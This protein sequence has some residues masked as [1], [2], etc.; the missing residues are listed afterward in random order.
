MNTNNEDSLVRSALITGFCLLLAGRLAAQVPTEIYNFLK[1]DA[2]NAPNSEG[3]WPTAGV[4][5]VSNMFYG[6]TAAGGASGGGTVFGVTTNGTGFVDLYDFPNDLS[7]STGIYPKYGLVASGGVLYGTTQFGGVGDGGMV[8]SINIDGTSP[9]L[10]HAFA[11]AD[12]TQPTGALLLFGKTLYGTTSS[13][14]KGYGTVF[15]I[16]TDGTGFTDLHTFQANSTVDIHNDFYFDPTDGA[17]PMDGVILSADGRTLYGTTESGGEGTN[18]AVYAM[19]IDGT[20]FRLLYS[21]PPAS[22]PSDV[23]AEGC[24]PIGGLLLSA[25]GATLYG[26]TSGGGPNNLG[27]AYSVST[28]GSSFT[29]LHGFDALPASRGGINNA[30]VIAPMVLSGDGKVLYGTSVSDTFPYIGPGYT[31]GGSVFALTTDGNNFAVLH[32]FG[33]VWGPN[34][35][36]N[37]DGAI[38]NQLIRVG[39]TLYSATAN[40]GKRGDGQGGGGTIFSIAL[41]LVPTITPS[42]LIVQRGDTI[43]VVVGVTNSDWETIGGVQLSAPIIVNSINGVVTPAGFSGPTMVPSLASMA[44]ASFTYLFTATNYGTA[45]FTAAVAGTSAEGSVTSTPVT[46]ASITVAPKA[47]LMVRGAT[48]TRFRGTGEFMP[49]PSGDQAVF[50]SVS[51]SG[52]AAYV[53]RIQNDEASASSFLLQGVTNSPAGWTVSVLSGGANIIGALTGGGWTT[54]TL[55]PGGYLDLQVTMSPTSAAGMSDNKSILISALAA[56]ATPGVLDSL[57]LNATLVAIPVTVTVNAVGPLPTLPGSSSQPSYTPGSLVASDINAPLVPITDP[58]TLDA[59]LVEVGGL[60]ADGVTPLVI[61]LSADADSLSSLPKGMDFTLAPSIVLGGSLGNAPIEQRIQV[62]KDGDWQPASDVVLTADAPVAYVQVAPIDSDD[63]QFSGMPPELYVDFVVQDNSGVYAGDATFK[64]RKP[65]IALV[66]GY[67]SPGNWGEDFK[68]ILGA[69]RPYWGEGNPDNFVITVK[70]GQDEDSGLVNYIDKLTPLGPVYMN[71]VMTLRQCAAEL[72]WRLRDAVQPLHANWAFTRFDM[73]CH[74]QGGLLARMLCNAAPNSTFLNAFRNDA[75]C[76]R[77]RFHRVVTIGSPHN[78]S[79]LLRYLL[80]LLSAQTT[81]HL[82][83]IQNIPGIQ[84]L[85]ADAAIMSKLAQAKFDPFGDQIQ[86]LNGTSGAWWTDPNAQFHLVRTLIDNGF[87][88]TFPDA[89]PGYVLLGLATPAGGAA[90]L[91]RGSDGIVDLDSMGANVPPAAVADNVFTVQAANDISH[92][93]PMALFGAQ[94][95]DVISTVV[96]QHVVGALDQSPSMN[97]DDIIFDRFPNPPLLPDSQRALIDG[98]AASS[99]IWQSL[100]ASIAPAPHA[101]DGS[102][103]YQFQVLFPTNLPPLSDVSWMV[104]VYDAAGIT[105]DGVELTSGGPSNSLVTVTVDGS[106][107]GDVVLSAVYTSTSNTV[108]VLSP[109]LV[110]SLLPAS[111]TLTDLQVLPSAIALPIGAVVSPQLVATYSDGSSSMRY[112]DPDAVTAASSQPSVVSVDNPLFWQ[113]NAAGSAQVSVTWSGHTAVS[114][115]TVFDN[116]TNAPPALSIR[117]VGGGQMVAAWA[118]FESSYLLESSSSMQQTNSWQAVPASA[119]LFGGW[120]TVPLSAT[121]AQQFFRLRWD[122]SSVQF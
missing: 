93:D 88:P 86:D 21:F 33:T 92:A 22:S 25:D 31:S 2:P 65:P 45:S 66:H 36:I 98:Y 103:P 69:S 121:N 12:G 75:N 67:A 8:C 35:A 87:C 44:S 58:D 101:L 15:A 29:V 1:V 78:G 52:T 26:C 107:V 50:Q 19:S 73:V 81:F 60:V 9:A 63:L 106:L 109:T 59:S 7:I 4:L 85:I 100:K 83:S 91:P 14:A 104:Q 115:I 16:G 55:A 62:L 49:T 30:Q 102:S 5:I 71:S 23:A 54:P 108:V 10:L 74:S 70:Y 48:E 46:S 77:G 34:G 39:K 41:G 97:P 120:T 6:A 56:D 95:Y 89:T 53:V 64:L 116:T 122:P 96:A 18:G 24:A 42:P 99:P 17:T 110:V 105:C 43:T 47:D 80:A 90:V 117:N 3:T 82:P 57:L 111:A 84:Q 38:P 51:G 13:G 37:V 94:A 72:E 119:S 27:T 40:G 28:G 32:N 68:N 112:P 114:Q 118:G 113:L 20:G 61:K 79:R 11:V 76:N